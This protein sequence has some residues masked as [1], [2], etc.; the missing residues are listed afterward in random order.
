LRFLGVNFI[1]RGILFKL[2]KLTKSGKNLDEIE[3][4]RDLIFHL[5]I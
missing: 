1:F 5:E 2:L 3:K 4:S